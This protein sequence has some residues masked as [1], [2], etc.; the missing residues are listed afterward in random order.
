MS[1]TPIRNKRFLGHVDLCDSHREGH[2]NCHELP[3]YCA[4]VFENSE[5]GDLN[6]ANLFRLFH[7]M[8]KSSDSQAKGIEAVE[9]TSD[10]KSS[11]VRN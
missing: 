2:N 8:T 7:H 3:N 9:I 6:G 5:Q 11:V 10:D 1:I 4:N